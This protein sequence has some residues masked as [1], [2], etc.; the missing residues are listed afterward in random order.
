LRGLDLAHPQLLWLDW[1]VVE[2]HFLSFTNISLYGFGPS[3]RRSLVVSSRF[4]IKIN[5]VL[6]KIKHLKIDFRILVYLMI[7]FQKI[8]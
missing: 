5:H 3:L 8:Q 1:L 2:A 6:S 7:F 4:L